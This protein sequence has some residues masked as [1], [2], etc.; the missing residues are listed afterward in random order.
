MEDTAGRRCDGRQREHGREDVAPSR[1]SS[2][3]AGDREHAALDGNREIGKR[4]VGLRHSAA[5]ASVIPPKVGALA[6]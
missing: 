3:D 6:P 5:P 4:D 1:V 2:K